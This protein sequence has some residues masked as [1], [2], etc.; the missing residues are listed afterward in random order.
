MTEQMKK[1]FYEELFCDAETARDL[2]SK[3]PEEVHAYMNG[4]GIDVT[5]E[6]IL[7][8]VSELQAE[9]EKLGDL[10]ELDEET[11]TAVSGGKGYFTAGVVTGMLIGVAF[12]GGW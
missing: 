2:M 7:E 5:L 10:Q 3:T 11:L 4:K 9:I 12:L 8:I 6:E 1:R